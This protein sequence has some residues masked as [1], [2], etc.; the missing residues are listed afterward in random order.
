MGLRGCLPDVLYGRIEKQEAENTNSNVLSTNSSV[1]HGFSLG[2]L[3]FRPFI[4]GLTDVLR[5]SETDLFAD[6]FKILAIGK[7][8]SDFQT[9]I[10]AIDSWVRRN[11]IELATDKCSAMTVLTRNKLYFAG[12]RQKTDSEVKDLGMTINKSISRTAHMNNTLLEAN[13][14]F[15]SIRSKVAFKTNTFIKL[16]LC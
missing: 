10:D 8:Q 16:R 15:Y 4:N 6:D 14:I 7:N 5:F 11:R 1:P 13:R 9:D 3:L 12:Q 2:T